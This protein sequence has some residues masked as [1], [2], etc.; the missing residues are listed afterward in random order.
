MKKK[1]SKNDKNGKWQGMVEERTNYL[2]RTVDETKESIEKL[3]NKLDEKFKELKTCVDGKFEKHNTHHVNVEKKYRTY[4]LI[5]GAIA[6]GG[7]LANPDSFKFFVSM[8]TRFIG[9]F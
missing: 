7:C 8:I 2:V 9:M 4:F 6:I 3:H 5:V 1:S